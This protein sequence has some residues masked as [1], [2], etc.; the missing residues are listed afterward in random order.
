MSDEVVSKIYAAMTHPLLRAEL[1]THCE[2]G[3][4]L[5]SPFED[6]FPEENGCPECLKL[7]KDFQDWK[8]SVNLASNNSP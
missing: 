2:H 1:V 4:V 6:G 3:S 7:N 5:A 8:Y